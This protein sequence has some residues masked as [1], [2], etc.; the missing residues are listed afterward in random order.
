MAGDPG[1][2]WETIP[3]MPDESLVDLSVAEF[4]ERLASG[5]PAPGGGSA[6]ALTGALAASLNSM[7]CNLTLGKDE[8]G[9]VASEIQR[10]LDESEAARAALEFGVEADAAA[11]EKVARAYKMPRASETQRQARRAAIRRGSVGAARAPLEVAQMC[12]R[13]LGLCSRLAEL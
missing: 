13:T 1:Q 7:V 6:A 5:S 11:F 2:A 8:F 12:A 3:R 9:D 4:L 10:L